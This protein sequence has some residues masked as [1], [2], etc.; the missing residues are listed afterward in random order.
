MQALKEL[1][2]RTKSLTDPQVLVMIIACSALTLAAAHSF[3]HFGNLPPCP[4]CLDQREAYWAAITFGLLGLAAFR[5][6]PTKAT[7]LPLVLFALVTLALGYGAY[8]AGYHAGVEYKWWAGPTSC[9]ASGAKMDI[10]AMLALEKSDVVLCDEI[11]WSLFGISMA[12]YNFLIATT[13]TLISAA[14]VARRLRAQ[15]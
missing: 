9:T 12:G 5:L 14:A 11:P 13:L 15:V 6:E 10:Q 7:V 3:E 1:I 4:L 2:H 8:L